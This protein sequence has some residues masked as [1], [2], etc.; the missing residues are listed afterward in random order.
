MEM[1]GADQRDGCNA[2][3]NLEM[4]SNHVCEFVGILFVLHEKVIVYT[5]Q[6]KA[7]RKLLSYLFPTI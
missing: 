5:E 7:A 3:E 1:G 2:P 4:T 6:L